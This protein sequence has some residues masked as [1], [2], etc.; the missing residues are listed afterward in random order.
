MEEEKLILDNMGTFVDLFIKKKYYIYQILFPLLVFL[1]WYFLNNIRKTLKA[2][3][4]NLSWVKTADASV[5]IRNAENYFR[6]IF[7]ISSTSNEKE[8]GWWKWS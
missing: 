3:A 8:Q 1:T 5:A 7:F 4:A 2:V 6:A